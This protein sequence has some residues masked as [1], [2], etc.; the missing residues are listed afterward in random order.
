MDPLGFALENFDALGAWRTSDGKNEIDTSAKL[1]NGTEITGPADLKKVLKS[2]KFVRALAEKLMIYA[3]GRGLERYD[4]RAVEAVAAKTKSADHRFSALVTAIV[5]SD[6]FLK[7]KAE[8][9]LA[10]Y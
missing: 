2:D 1:P 9:K 4:K 10:G 6:P 3:L 5:S 8:P 7:R